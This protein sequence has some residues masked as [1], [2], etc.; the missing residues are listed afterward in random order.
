MQLRYTETPTLA[1][2]V[3]FQRGAR[4]NPTPKWGSV[5]C[6][7]LLHRKIARPLQ[8]SAPDFSLPPAAAA[9]PRRAPPH[10]R[11][12]RHARVLSRMQR[13]CYTRKVF[14]SQKKSPLCARDRVVAHNIPPK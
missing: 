13:L 1:G 7:S 14:N 6:H 3:T 4:S 2:D 9:T 5:T 11:S 12:H 8:T 10:P